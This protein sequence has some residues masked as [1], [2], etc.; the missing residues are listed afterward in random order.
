MTDLFRIHTFRRAGGFVRH[1]L[2]VLG[3]ATYG[4]GRMRTFHGGFSR[5]TRQAFVNSY[6]WAPVGLRW[7][8]VAGV[9]ED[10]QAARG[11]VRHVAWTGSL[12]E[13]RSAWY[14]RCGRFYVGGDTPKWLQRRMAERQAAVWRRLQDEPP[15][16]EWEVGDAAH[17]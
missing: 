15:A 17:V 13:P 1:D 12:R 11:G 6:R 5:I 8:R 4:V 16:D 14:L 9:I 10:L 3:R 7:L 2:D